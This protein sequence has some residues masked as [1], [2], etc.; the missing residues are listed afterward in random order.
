MGGRSTTPLHEM[1]LQE[2]WHVTRQPCC[3]LFPSIRWGLAVPLG[4]RQMLTR[5]EHDTLVHNRVHICTF[6]ETTT[7]LS[8]ARGAAGLHMRTAKYHSQSMWRQ[9][10][11]AWH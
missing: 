3:E 6:Y 1:G 4:S 7:Q 10:S 5:G 2:Y 11:K 9:G 8:Y